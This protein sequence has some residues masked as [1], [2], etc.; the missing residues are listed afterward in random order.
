MSVTDDQDLMRAKIEQLRL[1]AHEL[2]R[3]LARMGYVSGARKSR[4]TIV[5]PDAALGEAPKPRPAVPPPPRV[6]WHLMATFLKP[7]HRQ[8]MLGDV[9][10]QYNDNVGRL[11]TKA[12]RRIFWTDTIASILPIAWRAIK[13]IGIFALI[14]EKAGRLFG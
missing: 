11:G 10:E 4:G 2:E 14:A 1:T 13:R 9:L 8:A 7:E 6:A 3:H 12:A 5:R